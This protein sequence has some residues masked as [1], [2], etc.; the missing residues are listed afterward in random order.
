MKIKDAM[1]S[2]N[3][4]S[5]WLAEEIGISKVAVS[6]IITGKSSPSV[7][8]LMKIS[9]ALDYSVTYLLELEEDVDKS[10]IT[11]PVCHSKFELKEK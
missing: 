7:E 9:K 6:N 11:C 1:I 8:T 4:T 3:V 5:A 2:R 10:T